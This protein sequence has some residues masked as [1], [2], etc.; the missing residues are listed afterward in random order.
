MFDG[1]EDPALLGLAGQGLVMAWHVAGELEEKSV[2]DVPGNSNA[3]PVLRI[4]RA[5]SPSPV[6]PCLN[7]WPARVRHRHFRHWLGLALAAC[8]VHTWAQQ[9]PSN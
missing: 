2:G 9:S 3:F 1:Q 8:Q 5:S 4:G 7:A 6:L